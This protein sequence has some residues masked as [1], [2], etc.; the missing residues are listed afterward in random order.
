MNSKHR[1][2]IAAI[3]AAAAIAACSANPPAHYRVTEVHQV[4]N[5]ADLAVFVDV[6][7]TGTQ[8][9]T[10]TCTINAHDPSGTYTGTDTL[11]ALKPL[12][13]GQSAVYRDDVTITSQG[14]ANVTTV[15]VTC[16]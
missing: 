8:A 14:A 5:P 16:S 10:P 13:P 3:G 9:T 15:T 1:A 11:T 12:P 6:T 2:A 7:N 4:I